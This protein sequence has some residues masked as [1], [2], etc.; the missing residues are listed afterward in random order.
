MIHGAR[1]VICFAEHKAAPESWLRKLMARRN[2]HVAAVAL[3]H[4][5]ARIVWALL[6]NDRTF[7]P[8]DT[9]VA[10]VAGMSSRRLGKP[11]LTS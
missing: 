9:P 8:D 1:A 4:K 3:A 2:K 11:D 10:A 6:T 7:R 5:N